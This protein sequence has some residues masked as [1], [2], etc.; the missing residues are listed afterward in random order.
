MW[1]ICTPSLAQ[2]SNPCSTH[3][4]SQ[5]LRE[6]IAATYHTSIQPQDVCV[7]AP[8]EGGPVRVK[9]GNPQKA[10]WVVARS[11]AFCRTAAQLLHPYFKHPLLPAGVYLTMHALLNPGDHVVCTYPG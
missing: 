5:A 6:A 9:I 8:E 7:C 4:P 11:A 1:A 10:E 3:H 2:V